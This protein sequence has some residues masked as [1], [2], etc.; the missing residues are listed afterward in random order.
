MQWIFVANPFP[1][2]EVGARS[3]SQRV[4]ALD[5]TET[6]GR[7]VI[8]TTGWRI[9]TARRRSRGGA[10][11]RACWGADGLEAIT[12]ALSAFSGF[13]SNSTERG[14]AYGLNYSEARGAT[15]GASSTARGWRGRGAPAVALSPRVC[16]LPP[17]AHPRSPH[18]L[19]HPISAR[20]STLPLLCLRPAR[21]R[22]SGRDP[23]AR[24]R[25]RR[26]TTPTPPCRAARGDSRAVV[27]EGDGKKPPPPWC[28]FGAD[29]IKPRTA[30]SG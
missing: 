29:R 27:V 24:R 23:A 5:G 19:A 28:W 6:A 12:G 30:R 21:G 16:P 7:G 17:E 2:Q 18:A 15:S 11:L 9:H 14:A 4:L 13:C 20:H 8:E 10:C 1:R 3:C 26:K 25:R 22:N